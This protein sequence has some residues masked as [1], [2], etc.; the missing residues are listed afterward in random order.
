MNPEINLQKAI[1]ASLRDNTM[2]KPK[3]P[4]AASVNRVNHSSRSRNINSNARF[5]SSSHSPSRT[6]KASRVRAPSLGKKNTLIREGM[7]PA[8]NSSRSSK[9]EPSENEKT[10]GV[11]GT[12]Q[13][14]VKAHEKPKPMPVLTSKR[15][16]N[17]FDSGSES[18]NDEKKAWISRGVTYNSKLNVKDDSNLTIKSFASQNKSQFIC[19]YDKD[20]NHE[21]FEI[22]FRV[23]CIQA[24]NSPKNSD[25]PKTFSLVLNYQ[26]SYKEKDKNKTNKGGNSVGM[27][28][29]T[30]I[31]ENNEWLVEKRQSDVGSGTWSFETNARHSDK[32]LKDGNWNDVTLTIKKS[33]ATLSS[34][35]K[36]IIKDFAFENEDKVMNGKLGVS[37]SNCKAIIKNWELTS[38]HNSPHHQL[39]TGMDTMLV[40]SIESDIIDR[41]LDV[42]WEDIAGL[43]DAKRVLHEAVVL[44][45]LIPEFFTGIREPWKGVLLHGPP[46]TG[47]TMLAKAVASQAKMTFFNCSASTLASKY[48]GESERL[49]KVLFQLAR[50]YSPSLIFFDEIDSLMMTRG[51]NTEHEAS[52]RL[53]SEI[54]SQIDGIN[55]SS[56]SYVMI[57][58]TTNKPYDIDEAMR[59][60]LEKRILI[61]LPDQDTRHQM[62]QL[63]LNDINLEDD[64]SIEKISEL[65][66]GYSGSDIKTM[67]RDA[68]MMPLRRALN[69]EC[70]PEKIKEMKENGLLDFAVAFSDFEQA[71]SRTK[72]TVSKKD[73]K[74]FHDWHKTYGST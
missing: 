16:T 8:S 25:D 58:A 71:I 38:L 14:D 28:C 22:T 43:A 73:M 36:L 34:N 59:R 37:C 62:L 63:N 27:Y 67:C 65:T 18:S 26:E 70:D 42:K 52:R 6:N 61:P 1:Y 29:L 46:G 7:A 17:S 53:K 44:P 49:S 3:N 57:L 5:R 55:S 40:H 30:M 74:V 4:Y 68:S 20:F 12:V 23:K 41:N 15:K 54:L 48:H 47:K 13:W 50:H 2:P 39:P 35:S 60:R 32:S 9:S 19:T 21:T 56:D 45:L 24:K 66:E 33:K 10:S 51:T 64:V 11:A 72:P 31:P 69:G